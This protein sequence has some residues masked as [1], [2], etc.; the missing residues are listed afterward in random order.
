MRSRCL[1]LLCSSL[2]LTL[3]SPGVPPQNKPEADHAVRVQMRNINYHFTADVSA[4][5]GYL[6]GALLPTTPGQIPVFD[7]KNSFVIGIESAEI[8]VPVSSLANVLNSYVFQRDDA[9]LK[10][11]AVS[12][13]KGR[14]K[15]TG[16]LHSKGD[17]P[18]ETI[19]SLSATPEGKIRLHTEKIKALHLPMKALMDLAGVKLAELIKTDKVKGVQIQ[20]DDLILDPE[21][22]FPPPHIR[23]R[24]TRVSLNGQNVVQVFGNS[25]ARTK[26]A[27]RGNYM[28]YRGNQLRFG[29]LTMTDTDLILIDMD[30]K[31]S[32]DFFLDHYNEQLSAGYTKITPGFG[33]RTYM[34]DFNKL[35][36]GASKQ[37]H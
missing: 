7:E 31:D 1:S 10:K 6:D 16:R 33:L 32:F 21:Q 29:K 4:Y 3:P 26:P 27:F 11:I 14:L 20:Q 28:A 25:S 19:G 30:P 15:I 36:S 17:I 2:V 37:T 13:D 24:V 35:H 23:G 22:V 18:F 9:P 5:I 12:I 34:R 8:A